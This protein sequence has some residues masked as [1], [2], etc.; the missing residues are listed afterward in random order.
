MLAVIK[1]EWKPY[2]TLRLEGALS[3]SENDYAISFIG[4]EDLLS[5]HHFASKLFK[6][7]TLY[8]AKVQGVYPNK[9]ET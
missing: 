9:T 3:I 1:P 5:H 8:F 6:V 7:N 4:L 2:F